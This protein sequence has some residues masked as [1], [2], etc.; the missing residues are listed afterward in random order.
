MSDHCHHCN[1]TATPLQPNLADSGQ[2]SFCQLKHNWSSVVV[3]SSSSSRSV[4]LKVNVCKERWLHDSQH[5]SHPSYMVLK[6]C[7][8]QTLMMRRPYRDL[9][10]NQKTCR[11]LTTATKK[12]DSGGCSGCSGLNRRQWS[13]TKVWVIDNMTGGTSGASN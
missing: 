12:A 5:D 13:H 8:G 6:G 1:P 10:D 7:S 11:P 9:N 3:V 4:S 2:A